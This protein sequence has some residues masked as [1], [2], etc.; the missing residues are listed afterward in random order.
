MRIKGNLNDIPNNSIIGFD[1]EWTKN[2]KIKNGNIPF[3]FSVLVLNAKTLNMNLLEEGDINFEYIQYYC[4]TPTEFKELILIA[5]EWISKILRVLNTCVLCGHQISSDFSVLYNIGKA[6]NVSSLVCLEKIRDEWKTRKKLDS[7]HIMDTRYDITKEFLGKSRR[8]VDM[9]KDFLLDVTQPELKS[10]SMTKLQN[11]F[12][13]MHDDSIYERIA[14]MN[15]RHSLCAIVLYWL[16]EIIV[17][18]EQRREININRSVY[19]C[20]HQDFEWIKSKDFSA[21]LDR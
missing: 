5:E 14:V 19:N 1:A 3:C 20:L 17:S 6:Y 21:L 7:I 9:C 13:D 4:E 10:S 16:N 12:Y 18:M 8:L 15:I 11:K 2:Y